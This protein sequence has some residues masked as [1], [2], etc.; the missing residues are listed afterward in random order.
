MADARNTH[1]HACTHTHT[2]THSFPSPTVSLT[3]SSTLSDSPSIPGDGN[4]VASSQL[5][6]SSV[7]F[8]P[9]QTTRQL[10]STG[11]IVIGAM[12]AVLLCASG[13]LFLLLG[14][15]IQRKKKLGREMGMYLIGYACMCISIPN[16][17]YSTFTHKE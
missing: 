17:N 11:F 5:H 8:S 15:Y 1:T 2:H 9:T 10:S 7:N 12:A 6:S 3:F 13:I 16:P 4:L 14:V